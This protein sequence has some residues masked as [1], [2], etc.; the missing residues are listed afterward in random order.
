M[1]DE[2]SR[3]KKTEKYNDMSVAF[4]AEVKKANK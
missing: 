3:D 2:N 1:Y 4:L